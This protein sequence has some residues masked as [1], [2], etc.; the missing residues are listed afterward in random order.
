MIVIEHLQD[1]APAAPLLRVLRVALNEELFHAR[2]SLAW[3]EGYRLI[4]ARD[5]ADVVGALG[6]RIVRDIHWGRTLYVDDLIVEDARRSDG[7]GA[8][9]IDA[10]KARAHDLACDHIRLC[11]GLDRA[12]AHR[13]YAKNGFERSSLQ[14]VFSLGRV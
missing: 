6:Y 10:A 14:F 9:L 1:P 8:Q 12:A 7:V 3:D 2:L 13:F 11:S 5:G 4:A